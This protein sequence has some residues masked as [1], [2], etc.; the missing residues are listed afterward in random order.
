MCE[1]E[2]ERGGEG[3]HVVVFVAEV[4]KELIASLE[5]LQREEPDPVVS[6]VK[7]LTLQ[8]AHVF[9]VALP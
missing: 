8:Q 9:S 3:G 7:L 6:C 1:R 5:S 2:R 4:E